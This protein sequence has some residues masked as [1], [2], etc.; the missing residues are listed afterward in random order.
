MLRAEQIE[1]VAQ[2]PA[3]RW[4]VRTVF[5]GVFMVIGW[6]AKEIYD[7]SSR[8]TKLETQ[9][10]MLVQQGSAVVDLKGSIADLTRLIV[11][12]H[13]HKPLPLPEEPEE[14]FKAAQHAIRERVPKR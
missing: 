5:A 7:H 3:V 10:A 13:E 4:S 12:T 8:I 14:A 11:A 6:C 9:Q 1:R 2:V